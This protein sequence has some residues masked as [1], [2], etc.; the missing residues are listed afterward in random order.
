L[1]QQVV[2]MKDP[3]Q[4]MIL[5]LILSVFIDIFAWKAYISSN[6]CICKRESQRYLNKLESHR[7]PI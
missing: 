7:R 4:V 1:N 2:H 5:R 3:F 6:W